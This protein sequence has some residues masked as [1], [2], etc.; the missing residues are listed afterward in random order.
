MF[1]ILVDKA[2]V[3]GFI[4]GYKIANRNGREVH[5]THLLFVDDTCFLQ[6]HKGP[7]VQP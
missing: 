3:E 2:I 4:S 7:D 5:I 1:S 6:G